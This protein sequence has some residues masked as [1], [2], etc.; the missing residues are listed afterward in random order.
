MHTMT[1]AQEKERALVTQELE[2]VRAKL[3]ATGATVLSPTAEWT[4]LRKQLLVLAR[5][6][7]MCQAAAA[8]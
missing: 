1:E 3:Q 7:K 5:K 8:R 6:Q 2:V 4:A